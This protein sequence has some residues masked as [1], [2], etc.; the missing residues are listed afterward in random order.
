MYRS[1]AT[2]FYELVY[3]VSQMKAIVQAVQKLAICRTETQRMVQAT[4]IRGLFH[5][6]PLLHLL[7]QLR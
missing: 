5:D 1:I 4:S 7:Q 2:H 3:S 6:I